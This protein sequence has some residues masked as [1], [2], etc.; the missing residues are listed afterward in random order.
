MNYRL[1]SPQPDPNRV[2]LERARI[3]QMTISIILFLVAIATLPTGLLLMLGDSGPYHAWFLTGWGLLF[4]SGGIALNTMLR[5]PGSLVFDNVRGALLV[6][7]GKGTG[8]RQAA[9]PY[10][11]IDAFHVRQHRQGKSTVF[12]AEMLKKDGAFW[13]LYSSGSRKKAESFCAALKEKVSLGRGSAL[14]EP[15]APAAVTQTETGTATLI[16]WINRY[17][18]SSHILT[19]MLIGSMA[20][21]IYGSRPF[22]TSV[23]AYYIGIA[24]ISFIILLGAVSLLNSIRRAHHVEISGA[25]LTYRKTG[26]LFRTGEF[27]VPLA[28]IDSILFNFSTLAG[29]TAIYVLTGGEKEMLQNAKRGAYELGDI[30]K[31]VMALKNAKKLDIGSLS[32]GDRIGLE[33]MLQKAVKR[34]SGGR[35][36]TL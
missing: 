30:M 29:E 1:T 19:V 22:A 6:N 3:M 9:V 7:E 34:W 26:G 12:I 2:V 21:L 15:A 20:M 17:P 14:M 33:A 25:A 28:E 23:A 18:L 36:R 31:A 4:L 13:T 5:L 8:A 16:E 32:T 10:A 11:D 24:F 35:D 27:T